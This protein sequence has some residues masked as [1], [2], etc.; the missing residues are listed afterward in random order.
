MKNKVYCVIPA[1][2][3]SKRIPKKN[4]K[5]FAGVP[6][7]VRAIRM[8]LDTCVFSEVFVSTDD[9]YIAEIAKNAGASV[10]FLRP[11]ELSDD[12]TSSLSVI[13]HFAANH[14]I[15][16]NEDSICCLYATTPFIKS[17]D[18]KN[19]I[20]T[21]N[22]KNRNKMIFAAKQYPH[23]IQRAFFIDN[24]GEAKMFDPN[25]KFTRTQDL[26]DSYFDAGQ[27][28]IA[29]VNDWKNADLSLERGIPIVMPKWRC[30]DI[31]NS[32]D[33]IFSEILYEVLRKKGNID[34]P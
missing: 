3:G 32:D 11:K 19:A 12:Y 24:V 21:F 14:K 34:N 28:Y 15:I 8:A 23:P 4:I 18:L 17:N 33:W 26:R 2:S 1:R 9:I 13:K 29:S 7:I 5:K 20:S 22:N 10:P 31:D 16:K 27:F 25:N 6:M 30:I